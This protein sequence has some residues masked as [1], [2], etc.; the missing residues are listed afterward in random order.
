LLNAIYMQA[1]VFL[2]LSLTEL[3]LQSKVS[4]IRILKGGSCS[5]H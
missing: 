1:V 5:V 3:F 2:Q 4:A